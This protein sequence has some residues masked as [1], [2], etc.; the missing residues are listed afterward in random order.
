M[1]TMDCTFVVLLL[2]RWCRCCRFHRFQIVVL[3]VLLVL[4][5]CKTD[6]LSLSGMHKQHQQSPGSR[7]LWKQQRKQQ[8]YTQDTEESRDYFFKDQTPLT[9]LLCLFLLSSLF[10]FFFVI[11]S[12][13]FNLPSF[14][15]PFLCSSIL[16]P[17]ASFSTHSSSHTAPDSPIISEPTG[18]I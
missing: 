11:P 1:H 17:P 12:F 3:L 13:S 16:N 14:H 2:C 5:V 6:R 7:P 9:V 15:L 10:Y 4:L 8:K 18:H